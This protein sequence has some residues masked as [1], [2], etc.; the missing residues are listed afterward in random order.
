MTA[1]QVDIATIAASL[2]G[3]MRSP[4]SHIAAL[5]SSTE[6]TTASSTA[7]VAAIHTC[8]PSAGCSPVTAWKIGA[9][10]AGRDRQLGEVEGDADRDAARA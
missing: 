1:T 9:G 7:T 4:E 8:G 5:T 2:R 3:S 6:T 10:D